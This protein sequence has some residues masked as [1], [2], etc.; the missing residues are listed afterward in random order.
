ME[1]TVFIFV[2]RKYKGVIMDKATIF[3]YVLVVVSSLL[4]ICV[5]VLSIDS[6]K[7][8]NDYINVSNE[9]AKL[10]VLH[11]VLSDSTGVL[12]TRYSQ[13]QKD[14]NA[15]IDSNQL[16]KKQ[17]AKAKYDVKFYIE[18]VEQLN[19]ENVELIGRIMMDST[20][21]QQVARFTTKNRWYTFDSKAIWSPE[22]KLYINKIE[23][24]DSSTIAG[25]EENGFLKGYITHSNPYMKEKNTEFTMKLESSMQVVSSFPYLG[26]A[27]GAIVG[28]LITWLV[29]K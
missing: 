10:D 22:P 12:Y 27:G 20:L 15:L 26:V 9:L 6:C 2:Q 1:I 17:L 24:Y 28:T 14:L 16:L 25:I 3:K 7:K 4:L 11:R 29:L 18:R 13:V 19:I 21:K 23:L 8:T 5:I